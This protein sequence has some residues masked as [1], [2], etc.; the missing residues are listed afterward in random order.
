MAN[1]VPKI[2]ESQSKIN[3]YQ[4]RAT[5]NRPKSRETVEQISLTVFD[6]LIK[7]HKQDNKISRI[8]QTFSKLLQ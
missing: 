7:R 1:V 2:H 8:I 3:M 6:S 5:D 4:E